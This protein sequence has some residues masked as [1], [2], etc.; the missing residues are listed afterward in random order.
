M[1][2]FFPSLPNTLLSVLLLSP[3]GDVESEM[4]E[5]VESGQTAVDRSGKPF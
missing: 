5:E 1:S 2:F 4:Y 3:C